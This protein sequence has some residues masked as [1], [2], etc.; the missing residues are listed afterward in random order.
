MN[1]PN[2]PAKFG[3]DGLINTREERMD[4]QKEILK[5]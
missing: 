2:P 1:V 5:L 3:S 4:K